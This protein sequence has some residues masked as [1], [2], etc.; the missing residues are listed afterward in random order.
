MSG[1]TTEQRLARKERARLQR[2]EVERR[3]KVLGV[4]PVDVVVETTL[5]TE[6]PEPRADWEADV[7]LSETKNEEGGD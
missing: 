4:S 5:E 7:P 2:K 3:A 6:D 1:L